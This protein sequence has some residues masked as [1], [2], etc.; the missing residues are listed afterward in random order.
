MPGFFSTDMTT[1]IL[2]NP[3]TKA[4]IISRIPIGRM[5][6]AYDLAG[7]AIFLSSHA[8]DYITGHIL[9]VDGGWMSA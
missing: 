6:A 5:G 7:A 8:S 3:E 1:D 2:N 4:G 9:C